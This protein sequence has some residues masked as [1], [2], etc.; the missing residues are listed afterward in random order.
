MHHLYRAMDFL[1]AH[2]EELERGLYFRVADLLNLGC[3]AGL[4]RH[5]LAALRDR[6]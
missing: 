3:G 1:E 4:L 2:K 5:H 6:R